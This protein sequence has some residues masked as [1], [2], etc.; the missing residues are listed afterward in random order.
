MVCRTQ[1]VWE[2][3]CVFGHLVPDDSKD[4]GTFIFRLKQSVLP[5]GISDSVL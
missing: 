2:L 4:H 5:R 1:V 3:N